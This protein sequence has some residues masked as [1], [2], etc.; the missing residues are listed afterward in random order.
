MNDSVRE[1]AFE[2]YGKVKKLQL[3]RGMGQTTRHS[4]PP[5]PTRAELEKRSREYRLVLSDDDE[6]DRKGGK[7]TGK[8]TKFGNDK[9]ARKLKRKERRRNRKKDKESDSDEDSTVVVHRRFK[10]EDDNEVLEETEEAKK[11]VNQTSNNGCT[12]ML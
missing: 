5:A 9:A 1:F 10:R 2:L 11:E 6:E 8:G 4:Q 3:G 7:K 12:W